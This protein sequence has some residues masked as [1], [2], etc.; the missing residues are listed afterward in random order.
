MLGILNYVSTFVTPV[1]RGLAAL[2]LGHPVE[3]A[4]RPE[5]I[6]LAPEALAPLAGRYLLQKGYVLEVSVE[7]GRLFLATPDLKKAEALPQAPHRFFV[8][9]GNALLTFEKAKD[10]SVPRLVLQQ[11]EKAFPCPREKN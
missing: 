10:G 3:P 5:G 1:N 8:K 7:G 4:Y 6:A 9:Q 2:A 11:G